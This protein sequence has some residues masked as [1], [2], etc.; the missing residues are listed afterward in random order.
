MGANHSAMA[1]T[2]KLIRLS[3]QSETPITPMQA[4]KLTYF[5][6]A[7]MLGLGHGPLFQDAVES[8]QYG[9]VIRTVYHALK[10]Y[11]DNPITSPPLPDQDEF[12]PMEEAVIDVVWKQ[13]GQ[14][15]GIRLSKMTH[16]P[17]SPW[18]QTYQRDKRSTIIHNHII[19]DYY[20][21]IV[22]ERAAH[23]DIQQQ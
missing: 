11:Q 16:A 5:C 7:W 10:H 3:L 1:V 20:A 22:Q 14:I 23:R 15:D 6:H 9:P 18:D 4:Q 12:A 8:W 13:Y 19:R 21:A 17:G 2:D